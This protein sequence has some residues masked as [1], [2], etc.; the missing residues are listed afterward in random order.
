MHRMRTTVLFRILTTITY[1]ITGG[2]DKL[3][4]DVS[5]AGRLATPSRSGL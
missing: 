5:N 2:A 4:F 1:S 3:R